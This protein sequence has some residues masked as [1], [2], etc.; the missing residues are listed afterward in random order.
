MNGAEQD[1]DHA[2]AHHSIMGKALF[3]ILAPVLATGASFVSQLEAWLRVANLLGALVVVV[4][5]VRSLRKK[6]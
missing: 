4:F 3:G 6:K 2:A 5:T 1:Q